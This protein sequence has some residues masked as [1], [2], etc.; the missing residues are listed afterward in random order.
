[1]TLEDVKREDL[2]WEDKFEVEEEEEKEKGGG[3]EEV[4][5]ERC[6]CL[7][8]DAEMEDQVRQPPPKETKLEGQ[9][10]EMKVVTQESS[11]EPK[12]TVFSEATDKSEKSIEGKII[13]MGLVTRTIHAVALH[14]HATHPTP[15]QHRN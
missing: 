3:G 4:E 6:V 14:L 11:Q 8:V 9:G 15:T 10:L 12:A 2:A 7:D 13:D 1:M 5:E